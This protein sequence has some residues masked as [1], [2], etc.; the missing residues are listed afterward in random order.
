[1]KASQI[2]VIGT[3][4][5]AMPTVGFAQNG[6]PV[7]S[8]PI[9][10]IAYAVRFD[11]ASGESNTLHVDMHFDATV[12]EPVLL[13]LPAWTPGAYEISNFARNVLN[14]QATSGTRNLQW[15]KI[16]FDTWRVIPTDAQPV[17]ISFDY[18]ADS[19]DNAMAW[20]TSDFVMFNGT[21]VFLYPEGTDFGFPA[22][23]TVTTESDWHV[24]SGF[25][26]TQPGTF[27]A[28]DYHELV[29]K[30]V[31]IGHMD[32]DSASVNGKWYRLATYPSGAM[33][34]E[35]RETLW[36]QIRD[37]MPPM[38]AVFGEVP[39][40][41]YTTL[42]IFTEES[43]GGSALEHSNSH[44]GIYNPAFIGNPLL[45]SITAHEIFHAWNV[46]RLR[47]AE[48]VPYEYSRPQATP[49]LWLSEG[50]TDY[51]ADLAL[52]RGNIVPPQVFYQ[53]TAG[54]IDEVATIAP[55]ALED[56]SLSTWID[57][58]DGT[59]YVYYPKGSLVGLLIDILIR[60]V[61]NNRASL[62]DVLG[63]LYDD[64]YHSGAG[65]TTEDFWDQVAA[66]A[67]PQALQQ[68]H[69]RYIDGRDVLPYQRTLALA[70]LLYA[71]DT[72]MVPLFGISSSQDSLGM[73][74]IEVTPG[75]AA[76]E[77]GVEEDDYLL[78]IG[79]IA[80]DSPTFVQEFRARFG[81]APDGADL[82]LTV[83][84][85]GS[86]FNLPGKLRYGEVVNHRVVEDANASPKATRIREGIL[87][88]R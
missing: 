18:R 29:D 51:Y 37:M 35:G 47:P 40:E 87:S 81:R 19:L 54:K 61:S 38:A 69:S 24:A 11:R 8:A 88:G 20:S 13:S 23:V 53:L 42:L 86:V 2:S 31:F 36:E 56:A 70:G 77:A 45:A 82:E 3:I 84:R 72:A 44:V 55:V 57:P 34:G 71:A 83:R 1:M 14:F 10:D 60:D 67:G 64:T 6:A 68:F 39:W 41:T 26:V 33:T 9:T 50:I 22:T 30:P 12:S 7:R 27:A 58:I 65:F 74:V 59:R 73:R 49:L 21:N 52:V 76:E 79:G 62:D 25:T 85:N 15:D 5:L 17:T 4:A 63:A 78:R 66:V 16:D 28:S 48:M 80:I 43:P 32:I 46:K 75:S